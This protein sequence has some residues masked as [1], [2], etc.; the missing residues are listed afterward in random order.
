MHAQTILR[1]ADFLTRQLVLKNYDSYL[2]SVE[3]KV[4]SGCHFAMT[5][6]GSLCMKIYLIFFSN[7]ISKS[8]NLRNNNEFASLIL[9]TFTESEFEYFIPAKSYLYF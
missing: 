9:I 3:I 1:Q 4:F 8:M 5:I 6:K 7:N 2:W